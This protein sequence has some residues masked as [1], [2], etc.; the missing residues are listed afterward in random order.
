MTRSRI[1]MTGE[2][3]ALDDELMMIEKENKEDSK[4]RREEAL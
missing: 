3:K 4:R 2:T 1:K